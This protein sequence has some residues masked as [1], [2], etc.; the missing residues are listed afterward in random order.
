[1]I[2]RITG[3]LIILVLLSAMRRFVKVTRRGVV[4]QPRPVYITLA[5]MVLGIGVGLEYLLWGFGLSL[6]LVEVE[7]VIIVSA[8]VYFALFVPSL[9][10]R[11]RTVL[12]Y[13][14]P[15]SGFK[16]EHLITCLRGCLCS[17]T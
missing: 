7:A 15:I 3:L 13:F 1:M 8:A 2:I 14:V 12:V 4:L 9:N 6:H 17:P 5:A 16:L 11:W 10:Q